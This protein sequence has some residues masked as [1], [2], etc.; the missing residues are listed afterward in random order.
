MASADGNRNAAG[1]F[2]LPT[3]SFILLPLPAARNADVPVGSTEAEASFSGTAPALGC[4]RVRPA[5]ERKWF[6]CKKRQQLKNHA[7]KIQLYSQA[8]DEHKCVCCKKAAQASIFY[9][10]FSAFVLA[11]FPQ[12]QKQTHK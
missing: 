8:K 10:Y 9:A 4:R 12:K 7:F 2:F 1:A 11:K 3:S 6:H 5:P